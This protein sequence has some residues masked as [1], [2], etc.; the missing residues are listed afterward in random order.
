MLVGRTMRAASIVQPDGS[1]DAELMSRYQSAGD[2]EAFEE[3]F[4]RHKDALFAFACRLAGDRTTAEDVS[5]QTWLKVID[6]ARARAYGAREGASFRTWLFTLARNHYVDQ[7][8]RKASAARE[9]ET[10]AELTLEHFEDGAAGPLAVLETRELAAR[11][12]EAVRA[13]PFEQREVI[14]FWS[15]GMDIEPMQQIIGAPRDT[16]LS[17]KKYA[18]A[19]LRARL[20][21]ASR[22]NGS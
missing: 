22:E 7:Y 4:R 20:A 6:A 14:A 16:I 10:C 9:V 1:D 19:K 11:L 5:Q 17:R 15:L 8:R 12:D 21:G 2:L 3:L 18:L 13:L